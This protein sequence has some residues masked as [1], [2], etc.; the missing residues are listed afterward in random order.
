MPMRPKQM[1]RLLKKNGF[2]EMGQNG[3][4]LKMF[5]PITNRV[6]IVPMHAK[7]LPVGTEKRILK[8]AGLEGGH[9]IE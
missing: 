1:V 3:S 7:D 8:E 5:N 6:T 2:K 9:D 4:H